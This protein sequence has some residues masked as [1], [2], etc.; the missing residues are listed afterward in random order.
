M[1]SSQP[2]VRRNEWGTL[3]VPPLGLWQPHLSVSIVMPAYGAHQTLPPVL[4]G[5]AAQSTPA[6]SSS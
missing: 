2:R 4:A 3:L 1:R 6:T 5:L